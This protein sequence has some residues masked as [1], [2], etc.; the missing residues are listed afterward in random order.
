MSS[1]QIAER[2]FREL[3]EA[4]AKGDGYISENA[5][6]HRLGL[7]RPQLREILAR[8]DLFGRIEK[9]QKFGIRLRPWDD[10]ARQVAIDLRGML[11]GY[12]AEHLSDKLSEDDF[13]ALEFH[14]RMYEQ[15]FQ[16][17][18]GAMMA[19]HDLEFHQLL[20]DR[21]ALPLMNRIFEQLNLLEMSLF[22][23]EP[24]TKAIAGAQHNPIRHADIVA[25]LRRS[26]AEGAAMLRRHIH[27]SSMP[28]MHPD[29][30]E[31]QE[32]P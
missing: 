12:M 3:G 22:G 18:D 17:S 7:G 32:E 21:A 26:A 23:V 29:C 1:N 4:R 30:T 2:V 5:L 25:A 14:A 10:S 31:N 16:G 24:R 19:A 11:E 20:I 13:A 27:F 28:S 6:A 9:K 15:G 8:I